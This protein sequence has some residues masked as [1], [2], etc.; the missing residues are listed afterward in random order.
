AQKTLETE[1]DSDLGHLVDRLAALVDELARQVARDAEDGVAQ[2]EGIEVAD[3]AL[4]D[5]LLDVAGGVGHGDVLAAA[6]HRSETLLGGCELQQLD[7]IA[8]LVEPGDRRPDAELDAADGIGL[9][10]DGGLLPAPQLALGVAQDLEEELLL[11][12]EVPIEDAL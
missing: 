12:G 11:G 4:D 1:G 2:H 5:A 10:C 6:E 8:V 3:A 7:N 9:V